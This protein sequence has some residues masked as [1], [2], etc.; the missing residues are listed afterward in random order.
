[1]SQYQACVDQSNPCNGTKNGPAE[2]WN[3]LRNAIN[4]SSSTKGTIPYATDIRWNAS[5]TQ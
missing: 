2:A 1:M 5:E 4:G 3:Q